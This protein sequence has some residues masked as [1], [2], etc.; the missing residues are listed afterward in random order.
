VSSTKKELWR[1]LAAVMAFLLIIVTFAS[2]VADT[3]SGRINSVLGA[4]TSKVVSTGAGDTDTAYFRSDYGTDIYDLGQL[5]RLE[6][7]AA[8]E[9]VAQVEQGVV[10]LKNDNSALPLAAGSGVTLFGQSTVNPFYSYHSLRN[11]MQTLVTY[12]DAMR[13]AYSVN[14]TL[15][16]P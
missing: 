1:G 6:E 13:G 4:Q 14:E 8:A 7:D 2:P 9:E 3:Y 11:S 16:S 5:A 15:V 10:L 12:A